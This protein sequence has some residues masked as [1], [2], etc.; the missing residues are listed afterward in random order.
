MSDDASFAE[1]IA[2]VRA[3]DVEAMEEILLRFGPTILRT[4]R[5]RMF[6][7]RLRRMYESADIANSVMKSF[8]L[9]IADE[10][11]TWK[12]DEPADLANLLIS[13]TD[14]KVISKIRRETAKKRGG[15]QTDEPIDDGSFIGDGRP[16]P[17]EIAI[18]KEEAA[19]CWALLDPDAQK[20]FELRYQD[21]QSWNEIGEK[22]GISG[23]ACRKK[24][25]RSLDE[26]RKQRHQ[27]SPG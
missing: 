11:N 10:G 22:L 25:D 4:A 16:T 3:R 8:L 23:E 7:S 6:N 17:E 21:E 15:G 1:L 9:R 24:L 18:L 5:M 12:I 20:I 26:V 14:R 2:R 13:M 27:R 19:H